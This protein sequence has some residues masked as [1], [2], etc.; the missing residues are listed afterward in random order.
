[1]PIVVLDT[2]VAREVY[3]DAAL[4]V[5]PADVAGTA[6]AIERLLADDATRAAQLAHATATLERY[7]W[8]EAARHTLEAIE[9]A[10]VRG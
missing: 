4:Y 6:R 7:C 10:G 9:Q 1:M 2:P 8:Q 3:G 5:A